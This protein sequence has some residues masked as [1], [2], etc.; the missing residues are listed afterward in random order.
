MFYCSECATKK[1]WPT[2]AW[3][4]YG[5]CECCGE[6]DNCSDIPSS[7][8]HDPIEKNYV[9]KS[10]IDDQLKEELGEFDKQDEASREHE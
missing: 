6:V 1:D 5:K 9:H 4:S 8:L 7:Q 2:S 3:K 10:H